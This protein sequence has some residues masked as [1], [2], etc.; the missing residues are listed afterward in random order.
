MGSFGVTESE[1]AIDPSQKSDEGTS[2]RA[3]ETTAKQFGVS[4]DTMRKEMSIV[5]HKDLLDPKDF[6]DLAEENEVTQAIGC[7]KD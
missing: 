1:K 7:S 6:A 4:R 5:E 3:D 2:G